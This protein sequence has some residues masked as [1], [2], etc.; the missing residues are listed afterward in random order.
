MRSGR[1]YG[2]KDPTLYDSMLEVEID[3][4]RSIE[5]SDAWPTLVYTS[6]ML[7]ADKERYNTLTTATNADWREADLIF[8]MYKCKAEVTPKGVGTKV[9][10]PWNVPTIVPIFGRKQLNYFGLSSQRVDSSQVND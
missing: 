2:L 5:D 10:K 1:R 4:A 9:I 6:S 8:V 3:A 7:D